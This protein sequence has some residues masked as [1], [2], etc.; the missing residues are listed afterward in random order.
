MTRPRA[1]IDNQSGN[2]DGLTLSKLAQDSLFWVADKAKRTATV[3]Q[4]VGEGLVLGVVDG[5]REAY[6]DK[7]ATGIKLAWSIGTG[8]MLGVAQRGSRAIRL[9]AAMAGAG[10]T[11]MFSYDLYL[12]GKGICDTVA[13]TWSDGATSGNVAAMKK[14]LGHFVFDTGMMMVGTS[15]AFAGTKSFAQWRASARTNRMASNLEGQAS[16]HN[17]VD[18][19][20]HPELLSG[21]SRSTTILEGRIASSAR[22]TSE[23][24]HSA[25][26]EPAQTGQ[27]D[28]HPAAK[29]EAAD[30]VP[31]DKAAD[32]PASRT[33]SKVE[34]VGDVTVNRVVGTHNSWIQHA[35]ETGSFERTGDMK[36]GELNEV[37]TGITGRVTLANGSSVDVFVR[38]LELPDSGLTVLAQEKFAHARYARWISDH[39]G[40]GNKCAAVAERTIE[41]DGAPCRVWMEELAGKN[42]NDHLRQQA[43]EQLSIPAEEVA[44]IEEAAGGSDSAAKA[45]LDVLDNRIGEKAWEI[46]E[47]DPA[48]RRQV[49]TSIVERTA[50]GDDDLSFLN[51]VINKGCVRNLA[52]TAESNIEQDASEVTNIDLQLAFSTNPEPTWGTSSDFSIM[53][54]VKEKLA[55]QPL[56]EDIAAGPRRFLEQFDTTPGRQKMQGETDMSSEQVDAYMARLRSLVDNGFPPKGLSLLEMY[57][58]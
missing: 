47:K 21:P 25:S 10:F 19:L 46:I 8:L 36:L 5:A 9:G 31:A 32:K 29:V 15:G 45:T 11:G 22:I 2:S 48:L 12:H 54:T 33:D 30:G 44:R 55:G 16:L 17:R 6:H 41:L 28:L 58:F 7:T 53:K 49:L 4:V 14:N 35:L 34:P 24:V 52:K 51:M 20:T 42:L 40:W 57:G 38:P 18:E 50:E 1:E 39:V 56:P 3:A 37:H 26:M 43:L 23:P 13:K 27:Q